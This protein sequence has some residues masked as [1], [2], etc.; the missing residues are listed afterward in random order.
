MATKNRGFMILH[1]EVVSA[2]R[3]HLVDHKNH[4]KADNRRENL[5]PCTASQSMGN[6]RKFSRTDAKH[7]TSK[8]KG[9][10]WQISAIK[11]PWVAR[12]NAHGKRQYLGLYSTENEAAKAYD[13]AAREYFGEFA[14]LNFPEAA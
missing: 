7:P 3:E 12:L 14:C 11:N 10:T 1:R 13:K 9:V 6:R 4:N 5:R 2:A 8:Y